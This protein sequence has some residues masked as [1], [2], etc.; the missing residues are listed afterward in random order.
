MSLVLTPIVR[1]G[2]GRFGFLD[3]PDGVRK[4]HATAVPR[5]GGIAIALA[6]VGTFGIAFLL[7]FSYTM[8]MRQSLPFI[9]ELSMVASVVFLTGVLD[10]QVGLSAWQKLIGIGGAGGLDFFGGIRGGIQPVHFR[11][12]LARCW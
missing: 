4:K 10:D 3:H 9:L 11:P 12:A 7:P 5:V 8:V 2:V 6:Y 1:D